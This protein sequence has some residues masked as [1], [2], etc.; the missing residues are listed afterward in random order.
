MKIQITMHTDKITK[1]AIRYAEHDAEGK[2]TDTTGVGAIYIRKTTLGATP[3]TSIT[4]T[5]EG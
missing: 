2:A 4:V 5:V 1:G 3:P